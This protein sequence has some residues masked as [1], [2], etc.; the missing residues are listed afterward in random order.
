MNVVGD[1]TGSDSLVFLVVDL[2]GLE[3][4]TSSNELKY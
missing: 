4:A 1:N 3:E 2:Q